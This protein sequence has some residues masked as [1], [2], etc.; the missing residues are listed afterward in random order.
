MALPVLQPGIRCSLR[1]TQHLITMTNLKLAFVRAAATLLIALGLAFQDANAQAALQTEYG[2]LSL[3][4]VYASSASKTVAAN[5]DQAFHETGRDVEHDGYYH[6]ILQFTDIVPTNERRALSQL[7]IHL[8]G[9]LP[10]T[11]YIARVSSNASAVELVDFGLVGFGAARTEH[12]MSPSFLGEVRVPSAGTYVI[13]SSYSSYVTS[14]ELRSEL[15]SLRGVS[16]VTVHEH[17]NYFTAEMSPD[18]V[19]EVAAWPFIHRIEPHSFERR[20]ESLGMDNDYEETYPSDVQVIQ[21]R[22][23]VIKS[24]NPGHHGLTGSGVTVG[25]GDAVYDG[26]THVDLRGRHT[27]LDPGMSNNG[28][29]SDHGNHTSSIL[30]GDGSLQPRFEGLAPGVTVYTMRTEA[31]FS[32]GLEQP[33]PMV[34][35]SN[36]WNSS[37]PVYGD[38]YEQKGRYN[39]NSQAIDLLLRQETQLLSVFSAGNSG[40][41]QAGYPANYLT[42][43][44]SYGAAKNTLVVG[45]YGGPITPSAAP[46]YGPARDGRIK[47]DVVATNRVHSALSLNRYGTKQGSSQSTPAVSGV[48][49]LLV[50]QFRSENGGTSPD[51]GLIKAILMNTADY[52]TDPGPSF[53]VGWGLVNARRASEVIS[54][55]RYGNGQVDHAGQV[56]IPIQIPAEIDGKSV[57]RVKIM[58]YWNDKEASAYAA[59]ALVNDLDLVVSDGVDDHLPWVLDTTPS[60]AASPA[61]KGV[62]SFNNVE[63]VVIEAPG[64]GTVT[65]RI[66][67]TSVPFGPQDF[68]LVYSFVLEELVITHPIGGEAFFSHQNRTVFWDSHHQGD[69]RGVDDV[70]YT[71]DGGTTWTSFHGNSSLTRI[72]SSFVVPEAP[73][74]LA[75]IR[76]TRDGQSVVSEPFTISERLDLALDVSPSGQATAS[77]N[78][79]SGASTYELLRLDENNIW[80]VVSSGSETSVALDAGWVSGRSAWLSVRAVDGTGTIHS[81]RADA[82]HFVV[83]NADPV[84]STDDVSVATGGF[85]E[86]DILAND[87]DPD[88][89]GL[90]VS[91]MESASNGWSILMDLYTV[92]YFPDSGFAGVDSFTYTVVD[93]MGGSATGTI[94]ISVVSGVATDSADELPTDVVLTP[95]YPNPF[96]PRTTIRYAVPASAPVLLSVYDLMGR[97]VADLVDGHR[98]AGWHQVSFDASSLAS[99]VYFY[100]LRTGGLNRTRSMLVLK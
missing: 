96:N 78:A 71:L 10:D 99:G 26:P 60:E 47:P 72:A 12:K 64:S 97:H 51:A 36:S 18:A 58:V 61:T 85:I 53:Q 65:A 37:D 55:S 88:G 95:N 93:G 11:A 52:V 63:Q 83:S 40:G 29:P 54:N 92:R 81:Q 8:E 70:A 67:G 44:P 27:I 7:G 56:D 68:Y 43:N 69:E 25:V 30:A 75:Q 45:R 24:D 22:A 35:S 74:G 77:W 9:Y 100:H 49:A 66:S 2:L 89:D 90:Y 50:E 33:D 28:S 4:S 17:A 91:A 87:Y 41:T 3:D 57:A 82:V 62:D 23:N 34:I 5:V 39:I 94:N 86:F 38:W 48:A 6:L 80:T 1:A 46:S 16:N 21:I 20:V 84:A 42:L 13:R 59:P 32:L 14:G 15:Q 76:L 73:L 79:V 19:Q 31:P 98:S